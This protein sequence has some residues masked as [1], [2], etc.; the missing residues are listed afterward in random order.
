MCFLWLVIGAGFIFIE[1]R[2]TALISPP[3]LPIHRA[4]SIQRGVSDSAIGFIMQFVLVGELLDE[5]M[6]L[7]VRMFFWDMSRRKALAIG[8]P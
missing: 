5:D 1:I 8:Y 6:S 7:S 2:I 3:D 4:V